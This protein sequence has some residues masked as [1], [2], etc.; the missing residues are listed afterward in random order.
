MTQ[1]L[2]TKWRDIPFEEIPKDHYDPSVSAEEA[3]SVW[4]ERKGTPIEIY[5]PSVEPR[6][7][8]C[9]QPQYYRV[10]RPFLCVCPHLVEI[11]D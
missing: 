2:K 3:K 7:K 8:F 11:G 6:I 5:I 10:D 1:I 9:S 4:N